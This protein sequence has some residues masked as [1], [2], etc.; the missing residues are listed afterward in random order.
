MR[1][2]DGWVIIALLEMMPHFLDLILN[3][4]FMFSVNFLIFEDASY[5]KSTKNNMV[6]PCFLD[7]DMLF[8][9]EPWYYHVFTCYD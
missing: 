5:K 9:H 4:A 3:T 8:E 6:L 2:E 1:F 7:I